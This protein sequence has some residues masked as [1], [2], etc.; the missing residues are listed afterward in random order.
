MDMLVGFL[1]TMSLPGYWVLQ[2][3]LARRYRG[4][5]RIAALAP[6]A[7]MVPLL[8]YSGVALAAG[9]N[10]WPLFMILVSPIAFVYLAIVGTVRSMA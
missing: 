10:L 9:S 6:L 1:A 8:I 2:I 7:V 5:W 4:G 3:M